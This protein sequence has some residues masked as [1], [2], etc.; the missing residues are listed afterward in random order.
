M[1][2]IAGVA[3]LGKMMTGMKAISAGKW[4]KMGLMF[5]KT[6][7]AA[8]QSYQFGKLG[9]AMKSM[10]EAA[11][12]LTLVMNTLGNI[13]SIFGAMMSA[14]LM[15]SIEKLYDI[16]LSPT[17]MSAVD[18][19]GNLFAML[20]ETLMPI[21][22]V[23]IELVALFILLIAAALKPVMEMVQVLIISFMPLILMIMMIIEVLV[24]FMV[25]IFAMDGAMQMVTQII[26]AVVTIITVFLIPAFILI[27]VVITAVVGVLVGAG[28]KISNFFQRIAD[29]INDFIGTIKIGIHGAIVGVIGIINNMINSVND[30]FGTSISTL[31]IPA[32]AAGGI[33]TSPT[34]ALIG[35]AGAEAV[36][37][38][39]QYDRGRGGGA[40]YSTEITIGGVLD[41]R[42]MNELSTR[43]Y[44]SERKARVFGGR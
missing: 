36:V 9:D 20:M 35:E 11:N 40:S 32:L 26:D 18:E 19:L 42:L 2:V 27:M 17:V 23:I 37:P 4:S 24:M 15:P 34:L 44:L 25:E 3:A 13:F 31:N 1:A 30:F 22:A 16:M 29:G 14:K 12:P 38:L 21:I 8:G 28:S 33:V 7:K 39:D 10:A 41:D 43:M 5:S 6:T